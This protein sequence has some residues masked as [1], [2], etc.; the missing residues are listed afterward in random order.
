MGFAAILFTAAACGPEPTPLP[1]AA[2]T[3]TPLLQNEHTPTPVQ[4]D[5]IVQ[6]VVDPLTAEV[7]T[8]AF[9]NSIEAPMVRVLPAP[10]LTGDPLEI[11]LSSQPFDGGQPLPAHVL[12]GVALNPTGLVLDSPEF[13]TVLIAY[14]RMV[15]SGQR[16]GAQLVELQH[17]IRET[18]ANAG[19]PDG[20][21]ISVSHIIPSLVQDLSIVRVEAVQESA[22]PAQIQ[23]LFDDT[24][25][26][27][28]VNEY[29]EANVINGFTLPLYYAASPS[30]EIEIGGNGLPIIAN[31]P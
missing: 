3:L 23:V 25:R 12:F 28:A 2:P 20:V 17:N 21:R 18:L 30:L 1:V 27:A 4:A 5:N 19:Y 29:G 11:V 24:Q 9:A 7:V 6:Y 15:A 13:M 10:Q 8:A 22:R 26:N 31:D 14:L 16:E